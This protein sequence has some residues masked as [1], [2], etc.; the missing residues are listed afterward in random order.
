MRTSARTVGVVLFDEVELIDIAGPVQVLSLAGRQWNFRPF[1]IR[2]VAKAAGLVT[3]RN[4]LRLEATHAFDAVARPE[5]V[6]VPGGYGARRAL[7]DDR[8]VTYLASAGETAELV[9]G[10]GWGALL[11]AKAGLLAGA[12]V[13]A[14]TE[15]RE[16]LSELEPTS[17]IDSQRRVLS[18]GKLITASSSAAGIDLGL[19]AVY[20]L[21]GA[22]QA[23][24]LAEKLGH[25]WTP[26]GGAP[27]ERIEILPPVE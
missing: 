18:S 22:K 2:P 21:L 13:A 24:A 8:L 5:L 9:L 11:L 16:L 3:T 17:V 14:P 23:L 1:K 19:S 6:L 20:R 12:S 7:D 15:S 26:D 10:V 25:E 4:Q 27:A